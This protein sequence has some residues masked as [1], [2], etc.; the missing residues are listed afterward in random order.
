MTSE[1]RDFLKGAVLASAPLFIP[2][3]VWGANDRIIYGLIAAGGR[4]RYLNDR[5]QNLGA[6]CAAVCDVYEPNVQAALKQSPNAKTYVDY[7]KLLEQKG[8]DA[9]VMAGPDHHHCPMLMAALAA[10]KDAYSEKPLSKSLEESARMVS[11]VRKSKQIN[12]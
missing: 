3:R 4:G 6:E 8:L 11:A 9:V 1:R 2:S 12:P 5:F 7:N 10:G